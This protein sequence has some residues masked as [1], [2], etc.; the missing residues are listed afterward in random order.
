MFP[1]F[2]NYQPGDTCPSVTPEEQARSQEFDPEKPWRYGVFGCRGGDCNC[3][4]VLLMCGAE[5]YTYIEWN[6]RSEA[7]GEDGEVG[8][9]MVCFAEFEAP[10]A[11]AASHIYHFLGEFYPWQD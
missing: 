9:T 1:G 6:R 4:R 7:E 8:H 11:E 5:Q 10:S 2:E 3:G